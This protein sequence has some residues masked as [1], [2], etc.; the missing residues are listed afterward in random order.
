[1]KVRHLAGALALTLV[2]ASAAQAQ[3]TPAAAPAEAPPATPPPAASGGGA[4]TAGMFGQAGQIVLM[5]ELDGSTLNIAHS[6]ISF[7]HVGQSSVGGMASSSA[8]MFSLTPMGHYFIMPNV[9]ISAGVVIVHGDIPTGGLG[10]ASATALGLLVGAG[11]NLHLTPMLS[12]WAQLQIGYV[13]ESF[14]FMNTDFTGSMVPLQISVPILFH[15]AEHFFLGLGPILRTQLSNSVSAM[16]VSMDQSKETDIG[17][18][19]VIGGY[20]GM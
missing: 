13:H 20:F 4:D 10:S 1:M 11:Y 8:N 17:L 5:T 19:A 3:D 14:S 12:A 15:P 18:T 9:S 2:A 7:L 16:G 6:D